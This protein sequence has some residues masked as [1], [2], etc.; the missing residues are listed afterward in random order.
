MWNFLIQPY[1]FQSRSFKKSLIHSIGEGLF[2]FFFL[3]FFQPF[4][5]LEWNVSNKYLYLTGFGLITTFVSFLKKVLLPFLFPNFFCEKNWVIWKEVLTTFFILFFISL[6]NLFYMKYILNI[7][8]FTF[9]SSFLTVLGI[10]IF[11]I[12]F[13]VLFNHYLQ[14]KKF[15]QEI[16]L[17]KEIKPEPGVSR[18]IAEN[19]K[20][21]FEFNNSDLLYIESTDNYCSIHYFEKGIIKKLLIRSTL[22]RI[23]IALAGTNIVRTHRSFMANLEHVNR[24]SG[25]AQGYKLHFLSGEIVVPVA[26]KYAKVIESLK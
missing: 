3:A 6:G 23:E 14:F 20:D 26:R 7:D 8:Y 15:S 9:Y 16:P 25:N 4:G 11:L 24:V 1:P 21:F 19:G 13:W 12:V 17:K 18:I 2:L 22:S 5:I 10:G